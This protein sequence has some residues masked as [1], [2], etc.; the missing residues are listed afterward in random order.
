MSF[1]YFKK[2][3]IASMMAFPLITSA[4]SFTSFH[5]LSWIDG[6]PSRQ[7]ANVDFVIDLLSLPNTRFFNYA[8]IA[9]VYFKRDES[10]C[11]VSNC[12]GGFTSRI[13]FPTPFVGT[14]LTLHDAIA[15]GKAPRYLRVV[16]RLELLRQPQNK[17]DVYIMHATGVHMTP[18]FGSL[19]IDTPALPAVCTFDTDSIVHIHPPAIVR[20]GENAQTTPMT[21]NIRLS[22]QSNTHIKF[23]ILGGGEV[24]TNIPGVDVKIF[25]D[26]ELGSKTYYYNHPPLIP[27]TTSVKWGQ[28][29]NA[30][31][32]YRA[33]AIM[34]TEF[35]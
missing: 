15:Q 1:G 2:L 31:G 13:Y 35:L 9:G 20:I 5:V 28:N 18:A 21:T 25:I 33:T 4:A 24:P 32:E 27:I 3:I 29:A 16:N 19:F 14:G 30:G 34:V 7:N 8:T 11:S 6:T 12:E 10:F 22:C 23:Y 17:Y 26:G